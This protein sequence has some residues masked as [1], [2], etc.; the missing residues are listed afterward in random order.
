[1]SE[2]ELY[3]P[4]AAWLQSYLS[5]KYPRAQVRCLVSPD[6]S[7]RRVIED[8]GWAAHFPECDAYDM[9][10]DVLGCI[11]GPGHVEIVF[12]EVKLAPLTLR[13]LGQLLG[14]C[15]VARPLRGILM[16]PKGPNTYLSKLLRVYSRQDVLS[17]RAGTDTRQIA[18]CRWDENAR[19]VDYSSVIPTGGL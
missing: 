8:E 11:L 16:S 1:M 5:G 10:I 13:D 12:V 3:D 19:C 17:Y 4:I 18:V 14:Y 2:K 15:L 6:I 9:Q 7:L